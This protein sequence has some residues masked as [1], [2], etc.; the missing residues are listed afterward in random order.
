MIRTIRPVKD[1]EEITISYIESIERGEDRRDK[2]LERYLFKC[3]CQTCQAD[4]GNNFALVGKCPN[5]VCAARN[6]TDGSSK[7]I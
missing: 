2:L 7:T 1:D 5:S 6:I 3:K 4:T